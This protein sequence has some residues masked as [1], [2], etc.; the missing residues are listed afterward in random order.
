[1]NY[2]I[3]AQ[4][5][6][7]GRVASEAACVLIGKNKSDYAPNTVA[8]VSVEIKNASKAKIHPKKLANKSYK[9][10]SGYPGG[11][12]EKSMKE[13]IKNKG[14]GELFRIAV[15]GML[16]SNKLRN[17]MLKNLKITE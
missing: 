14:Y 8:D 4:N 7:I 11:L 9:R 10:Y 1:M 5:K 6:S 15:K 16:P 2:I 17:S 12:K 13:M 3:D